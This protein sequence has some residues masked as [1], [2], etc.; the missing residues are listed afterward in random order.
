MIRPLYKKFELEEATEILDQIRDTIVD[1]HN[2]TDIDPHAFHSMAEY[3]GYNLFILF[4]DKGLI[5]CEQ[6]KQMTLEGTEIL[7]SETVGSVR[8]RTKEKSR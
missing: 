6:D 1:Y 8:R 4:A 3:V 5:S 2:R 7:Y